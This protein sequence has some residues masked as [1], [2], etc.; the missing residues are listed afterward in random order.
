LSGKHAP[1]V[2]A[3][4]RGRA[5]ARARDAGEIPPPTR[6][7]VSASAFTSW[8]SPIGRSG[9][10]PVRKAF[11]APRKPVC[12]P[13]GRTGPAGQSGSP[14]IGCPRGRVRRP[15]GAGRRR[16]AAGGSGHPVPP[17]TV[18]GPAATPPAA[19][20]AAPRPWGPER[21]TGQRPRPAGQLVRG[22]ERSR[23][24]HPVGPGRFVAASPA[25][26]GRAFFRQ[27]TS[28]G[29]GPPPPVHGTPTPIPWKDRDLRQRR[30]CFLGIL[31]G[32]TGYPR[33]R[34]S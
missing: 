26:L 17:A 16:R 2:P 28:H 21:I 18:P 20:R 5:P 15:S 12:G 3:W 4:H 30:P 10:H 27:A 31:A 8:R 25:V 32:W 9:S 33:T 22:D 19:L 11:R 29:A 14:G 24:S 34:T 1:G 6:A 7:P 23:C 13:L